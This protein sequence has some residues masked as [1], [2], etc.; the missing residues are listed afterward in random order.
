MSNW[1][2]LFIV[3]CSDYNLNQM[4]TPLPPEDS[5]EPE[6]IIAEPQLLIDPLRIEE[7]GICGSRAATVSLLNIGEGELVI[8]TIDLAAAGWTMELPQ[9]PMVIPSGGLESL[10]LEGSDGAGILSIHSNDPVDPIQWVELVA[11]IDQAPQVA[12]TS[13]YNGA[14]IP[15][16]G[17]VLTGMVSDAEDP[18]ELFSRTLTS[19][20]VIAA[21]AFSLTSSQFISRQH[22]S[23][24]A[25]TS[26]RC[27]GC[28][29]CL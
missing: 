27:L 22:V 4:K 15:V 10:Y 28:L 17:D 21:S 7:S 26:T 8:D 2:L 1:A 16:G 23:T 18:P 24:P 25:I 29:W 20:R 11:G 13:P 3:G 6:V 9:M 12:I 5:S 14:V 19:S